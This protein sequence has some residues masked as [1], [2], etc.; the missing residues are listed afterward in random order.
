MTND[1]AQNIALI[2]RGW[3]ASDLTTHDSA[4]WDVIPWKRFH[5][6][7]YHYV[8]Q[9]V[10]GGQYII[11]LT[12]ATSKDY[13]VYVSDKFGPFIQTMR[14]AM[15]DLA[16]KDMPPP[17]PSRVSGTAYIV[18]SGRP[19]TRRRWTIPLYAPGVS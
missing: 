12:V 15:F 19:G 2:L 14:E 16:P 8:V 3:E 6:T 9:P 11:D 13:K 5:A 10:G 17:P 4:D 7:A 18:L 1:W